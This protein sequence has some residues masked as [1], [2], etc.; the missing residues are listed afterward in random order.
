MIIKVFH[1]PLHQ[2]T[3]FTAKSWDNGHVT[4]G[5]TDLLHIAFSANHEPHRT[6]E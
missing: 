3:Q 1:I 6:L 2:Q 5:H 4:T